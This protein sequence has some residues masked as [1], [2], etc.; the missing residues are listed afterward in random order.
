LALNVKSNFLKLCL[1]WKL[2]SENE[3]VKIYKITSN[4]K[5]CN[6]HTSLGIGETMRTNISNKFHNLRH[7]FSMIIICFNDERKVKKYI[8]CNI[9]AKN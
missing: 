6:L 2:W 3:K 8:P 7:K 5:S 9:V 4:Y 1:F